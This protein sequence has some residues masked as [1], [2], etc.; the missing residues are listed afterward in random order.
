MYNKGGL[1]MQTTLRPLGIVKE[2]VEAIG[3]EITYAYEDLVFIE[4]NDYLI[5]FASE[6]NLLELFFNTECP[7]EEADAIA[8]KVVPAALSKGLF[9]NRKGTYTMTEGEYENIRITFHS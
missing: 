9:V 8:Q 7:A 6:P 3:H 5:Q 2:V 4:H 1:N